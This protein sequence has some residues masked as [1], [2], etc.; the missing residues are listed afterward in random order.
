MV[1]TRQRQRLPN[2]CAEQVFRPRLAAGS[3]EASGVA[4]DSRVRVL[5]ACRSKE[6]T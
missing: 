3:P 5:R 6:S 1:S 4:I 2:W